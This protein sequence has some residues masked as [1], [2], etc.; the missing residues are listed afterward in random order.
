[1]NKAIALGSQTKTTFSILDNDQLFVSEEFKD[2]SDIECFN[3]YEKFLREYLSNKKVMPG[4]VACDL[5]PDYV[6]TSLAK[7][8]AEETGSSLIKVQHHFAHIVSCMVDN[9]IDEEVLGVCFD[10]MGF[11]DDG[12]SWGSEFLIC[13]RKNFK[14]IFHFKYISQPGSDIAS[15]EG[16]RIALSY[17]IDTYD[18]DFDNLD[19]SLIKRIGKEKIETVRHMIKRNIN[20][21]LTSSAGRLFDAVSSLI[22]ICDESS[23][24]A[25]AAIEL[26][27]VAARGITESYE[28]NVG[29]NDICFVPM[30][31]SIIDDLN[32]KVDV[33]IISA[34]FHNTLGEVIFDISSRAAKDFGISK[35]LLSGGCFQNKY[36]REYVIS[37]FADSNIKLFTHKKYSTTD[38]GVSIGQA[39]VAGK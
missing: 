23:F 32:E 10:G 11:G 3:R 21:P 16:W 18:E 22:G 37:K 29:E 5:H 20:S 13:D 27:K 30:I 4:I 33:G 7:Q 8:L 24:E 19:I 15:R 14:R 38:A 26:E 36:L 39:V 31:K 34:K 2:L 12:K 28:Y 6:S 35:V 9:D 17:L 1:M 25:E